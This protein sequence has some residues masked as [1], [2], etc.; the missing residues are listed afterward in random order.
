MAQS[1]WS[2]ALPWL[3]LVATAGSTVEL[4]PRALPPLPRD[5]ITLGFT[6]GSTLV[7]TVQESSAITPFLQLCL[8]VLLPLC[9]LLF[10]PGSPPTVPLIC[11]ITIVL[12]GT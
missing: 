5:V 9:V 12:C 1:G 4:Y 2:L 3:R 8:C 6:L 10:A 7:F 11:G